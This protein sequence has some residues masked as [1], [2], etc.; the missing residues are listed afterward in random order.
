MKLPINLYA[1]IEENRLSLKP[2]VG[3]KVVLENDEFLV[4]AVGGPNARNDYHFNEGEEF[5][6]QLKGD[7][8]LRIQE[9]GKAKDVVIKEGEV[10]LL[11]SKVPHS[12]V[13]PADT[14]GLVI[15]RKRTSMENDGLIWF[16]P[17]C[18]HKLFEEFFKLNSIE[19]DFIPVFRKF[20]R[21]QALRT[22]TSCG[23]EMPADERYL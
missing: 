13:R 19:E 15:E 22:C 3:N 7:I 1:W 20:N 23:Y 4:M 5:F 16:C 9:N 12:P 17:K 6:F 14:I 21:D 10:F 2:P 8:I 18:N 11:P